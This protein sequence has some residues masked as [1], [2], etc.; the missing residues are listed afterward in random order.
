M[1][2]LTQKLNRLVESNTIESFTYLQQTPSCENDKNRLID[3]LELYFSDGKSLKLSTFYS[4]CLENTSLE[5]LGE[6]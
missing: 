3:V 2:K 4:G 1:N 5:L 6:D